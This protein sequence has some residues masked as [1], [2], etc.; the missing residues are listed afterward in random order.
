MTTTLVDRPDAGRFELFDGDRLVAVEFYEL[1][2]ENIAYLHTEVAG[3]AE[4]KG[5]G[6]LIA[7]AVLDEARR[8]GKGVV[9]VCPFIAKVISDDPD[10]YLD[11]VPAD[12]RSSFG[13]PD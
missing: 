5:Y 7:K 1:R 2:G 6:R 11:L 3:D 13:L 12:Q 8:R 4:G 10:S 9:P